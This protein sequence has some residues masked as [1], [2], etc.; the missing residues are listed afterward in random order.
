M[1]SF[2]REACGCLW[3]QVLPNGASLLTGTAP[4][5]ED[6]QALPKGLSQAA[7]KWPFPWASLPVTLLSVGI[8]TTHLMG[9]LPREPTT[10]C[11]RSRASIQSVL[12]ATS[13][14]TEVGGDT[15]PGISLLGRGWGV[16]GSVGLP[17]EGT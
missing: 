8:R 2:P 12:T 11:A 13:V 15:R 3:R 17:C 16:L 9:W 14:Y 6:P 10:T 5:W 4:Q 1:A 7:L